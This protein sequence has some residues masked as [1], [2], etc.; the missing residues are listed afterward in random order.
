MRK[1]AAVLLFVWSVTVSAQTRSLSGVVTEEGGAPLPGVSVKLFSGSKMRTFARTN[2]AGTYKIA[3]PEADSVRLVFERMSYARQEHPLPQGDR[4]DVCMSPAAT[5]LKEVVISAPS[6]KLR[7]DTLS[8]NLAAFVGKGDVSLEDAMKKIPGITVE[9]SGAIKYLGKDIS[10]FYVEGLEMLGGRY[11]LATRNLP[12]EYVSTVE[13]LNNHKAR[14][15]DSDKHSDDVAINVRLKST[16]RV[17][18]VGTYEGA[19]GYENGRMLYR[20]SGTGMIFKPGMQ[21]LV[22]VKGGNVSSFSE[23]DIRVHYGGSEIASAA[24]SVL[25]APATGGAPVSAARY[26]NV[27]DRIVSANTVFKTSSDGTLRANAN[28]S[29]S[30]SGSS[31][32]SVTNYF[33][34]GE[35]LVVEERN[36]SSASS[37]NP[38]FEADYTLN[39]TKRYVSNLLR[40]SGEVSHQETGATNNG[41]PMSQ[42][43]RFRTFNISDRFRFTTRIGGREWNLFSYIA[44]NTTPMTRLAVGGRQGDEAFRATQSVKSTT[45]MVNETAYS[46]WSKGNSRFYLNAGVQYEYNRVLTGLERLEGSYD[47]RIYSTRAEISASPMYEYNEPTNRL[48]LRLILP[49]R[50]TVLRARNRVTEESMKITQPSFTPDA[51]A[52]WRINCMSEINVSASYSNTVGDYLDLLNNPVQTSYRAITARSGLVAKTRGWQCR[53]GYKYERPFDYWLMRTGVQ[54]SST[55]RN[56]LNSQ[57]VTSGEVFSTYI[58]SPNATDIASA[59]VILSKTIPSISTKLDVTG[60]YSWSRRHIV[61]QDIPVRYYG[62]SFRG[63]ISANFRPWR[64]VEF[65]WRPSAG[66]T[67][68]SYIGESS[69]YVDFSENFRLSFYPGGGVELRGALEHVRKQ[70]AQSQYKNMALLDFKAVWKRGKWRLNI[71]LDNLLDRRSYSYTVFN[72]VDTWYYDYALRGRSVVAGVSYTL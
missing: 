3:V 55:R 61:Q 22:S 58:L 41:T 4:L 16:V 34:G 54:Y 18:P 26:E 9:S 15:I 65:E 72:G 25:P 31:Y 13:V 7:G 12:A 63:G 35:G 66:K 33:T 57:Y 39:A 6:V 17:R 45:V 30:Y 19:A 52:Y 11:S 23:S 28:Y 32:S 27:R 42:R 62:R 51:Y 60:A 29:Y 47:N 38:A 53:L 48:S 1:A 49:V 67:I 46:S 59:D 43:R 8:F 70:V 69:S 37:H 20:I 36:E 50:M 2:G 5:D 56:M 40:F 14:K 21:S 24:A 68:C 10:N 44:M 71:A 64:F